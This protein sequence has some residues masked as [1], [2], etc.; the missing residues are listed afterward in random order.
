MRAVLMRQRVRGKVQGEK[1]SNI[2]IQGPLEREYVQANLCSFKLKG[3]EVDIRELKLLAE[4][5]HPNIVKFVCLA[6]PDEM[7]THSGL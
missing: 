6:C 4:F 7:T 1:S 5:S 2:G 3:I